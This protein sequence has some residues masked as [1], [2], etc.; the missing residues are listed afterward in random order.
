[1]RRTREIRYQS[2]S[3]LRADLK[4]LKR[5]TT[6][7]KLTAATSASVATARTKKHVWLWAAGALALLLLGAAAAWFF[8][9][10]PQPKIT[11][12]N[13]LT[14]GSH[15]RFVMATDGSRLYFQQASASGTS[16]G[17]LAQMSVGGG[18]VSVIPTPMTD[19]AV[20]DISPDHSHLL[21]TNS[22]A[23]KAPFWNL[24]LPAGSPRIGDL[25]A[26]WATWSPDGKQLVFAKDSDLL[27]R[28]S[29]R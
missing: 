7:G 20:T 17:V 24:P 1:L 25:E 8:A 22:T 26:N 9:P 21:I 23:V 27:C 13:Q 5:E 16:L 28:G 2:A 29:G 12:S 6:S 18:D 4:R 14:N 10:V 3:E 15:P 11:G 19:P